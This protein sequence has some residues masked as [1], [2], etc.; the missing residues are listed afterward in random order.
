VQLDAG[1]GGG[2]ELLEQ[3]PSCIGALLAVQRSQRGER[4]AAPALRCRRPSRLASLPHRRAVLI[5]INVAL[6]VALAVASFGVRKARIVEATRA[7]QRGNSFLQD[8]E[9]LQNEVDVLEY[10][11]RRQRPA[12]D[13]VLAL[14]EALP[15]NLKIATLSVSP[16]GKIALTGT[17]ATVEDASDKAIAALKASKRFVN[18]KF[19]GASK[20]EQEFKFRMTFELRPAPGGGTP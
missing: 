2:K 16:S 4:T 1:A 6:A 8:M 11:G 7:A 19:L 15:K 17:C 14:A 9:K 13:T 12:L 5:G 20:Q 3:F 18:P 10:E